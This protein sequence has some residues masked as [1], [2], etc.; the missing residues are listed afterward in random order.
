MPFD[1]CFAW[2]NEPDSARKVIHSELQLMVRELNRPD[3]NPVKGV[4]FS[5]QHT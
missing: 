4:V 3:L 2:L 5:E 1:C